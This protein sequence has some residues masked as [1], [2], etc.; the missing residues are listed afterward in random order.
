[1]SDT[2]LQSHMP[3]L[4]FL[5]DRFEVKTA[6]EFGCGL[7]S[8]PLLVKHCDYVESREMNSEEWLAKVKDH[9]WNSGIDTLHWTALWMEGPTF[10]L[11]GGPHAP[12]N[13]F[14]L[15]LCDG[16][17]D[18]RARQAACM[19][20]RAGIIVVHDS[21]HPET[22][23]GLDYIAFS[24]L[25]YTRID[26]K[27]WRKPADLPAGDVWPWTTVLVNDLCR[28]KVIADWRDAG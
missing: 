23:R 6:L 22:N 7:Y 18:T 21:Q 25:D 12:S 13:K 27:D 9:F 24:D 1:M 15:V 19:I 17:G 11:D 28:A 5:L 20:N 8:T 14:D 3:I 16:H 4:E 26:F 2:T 10:A